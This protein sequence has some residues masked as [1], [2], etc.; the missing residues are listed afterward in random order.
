MR[1]S[2]FEPIP[3]DDA[4]TKKRQHRRNPGLEAGFF[5]CHPG[6]EEAANNGEVAPITETVAVLTIVR[7]D[8]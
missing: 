7:E 1:A 8:T 4:H 2:R 3:G 5:A 6:A